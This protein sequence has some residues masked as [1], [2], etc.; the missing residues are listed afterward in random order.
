MIERITVD[1]CKIEI[2]EKSFPQ[3]LPK[4]DI[5][6]QL[7][8]N[9]FTQIYVYKDNNNVI[10]IIMYDFIYERCELTQI[11]VIE[12]HRNRHIASKLLTHMIDNCKKNNIENITLEVNINNEA[13]INLYKKFGFK[14][15]AIRKGYYQGIDGILME[16]EM[17]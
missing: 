14:Q 5:N 6:R 12:T 10:A 16:K 7:E 13:A 8:D 2:L 3:L 17:I 11:E 1:N 9:D 15:V 4:M